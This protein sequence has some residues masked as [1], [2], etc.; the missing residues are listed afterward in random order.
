MKLP[1]T[2]FFFCQSST[3]RKYILIIKSLKYK[4]FTKER[5]NKISFI[6]IP[7]TG[8]SFIRNK[9]LSLN[10]QQNIFF[11]PGHYFKSFF[12]KK[13]EEYF[14][15]IREPSKRMISAFYAIKLK[16]NKLY[17]ENLIFKKYPEFNDLLEDLYH[18]EK[19]N[20][21]AKLAFNNLY[22][23]NEGYRFFFNKK[24][25][26]ENKPIYI[27]DL[28]NLDDDLKVILTKLNIYEKF[29]EDSNMISIFGHDTIKNT[30]NYNKKYK[31]TDKAE[32]NLKKLAAEEYEMYNYI[33]QQKDEINMK[34]NKHYKN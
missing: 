5:K 29:F 2:N 14:F 30:G 9:L 27:I 34:F 23:L 1:S 10:K 12:L 21:L 32:K 28:N 18:N 16:K 33:M 13:K 26:E 7:R 25:F 3:L 11:L 24:N 22:V 19:I 8:G 31:L 15:V 4:I 6:H 17:I 20:L